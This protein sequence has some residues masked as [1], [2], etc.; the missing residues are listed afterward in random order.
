MTDVKTHLFW[1]RK[2]EIQEGPEERRIRPAAISELEI[3]EIRGE[4][5]WT[6]WYFIG[7]CVTIKLLQSK[8]AMQSE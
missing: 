8:L 5:Y 1:K 2:R 3:E 6:L 7:I 4:K